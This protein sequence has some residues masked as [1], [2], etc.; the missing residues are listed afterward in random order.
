[1][2]LKKRKPLTLCVTSG[3]GG[4]GKT[5][6][7]VNIAIAL[8]R[9]GSRVLVVDGD[10]GLA[11]VDV[12]LRLSVKHNIQDLLESGADPRQA[13]MIVR[14]NL[15]V[16]PGSSGVP[17]MVSLGEDQQRRLAG[18][19]K[20][21]ASD[22]DYILIDTAAGIGASVLWY[23]RFCDH[24]L[25]I[26]SPDPT[27]MTDAYALI[28]LLSRDHGIHRFNLVLNFVRTSREGQQTVETLQRVSQR[29]L[30][31]ELS[32]LGT[33]PEDKAVRSAV[34]DQVPFIEQ[35]PGSKAARAIHDIAQRID[36]VI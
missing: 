25:F 19:I 16:L 13:L 7:T 15:A 10:M 28:K 27:S 21:V 8:A 34:L 23:N 29:F 9:N 32:H 24:N 18:F 12:M 22:Y 33:I 36:R 31:L 1:M 20:T 4:V 6:F 2:T 3:K 11:N 26:L 35:S 5:S 17:E 14:P 30:K